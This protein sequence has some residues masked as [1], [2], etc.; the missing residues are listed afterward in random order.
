M[1]VPAGRLLAVADMVGYRRLYMFPQ[2]VGL[3]QAAA[4]PEWLHHLSPGPG[5]S[6]IIDM[7]TSLCTRKK[8]FQRL[9]TCQQ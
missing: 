2:T 1:A 9:H 7:W 5:H 3:Q 4:H 8:L 6:H